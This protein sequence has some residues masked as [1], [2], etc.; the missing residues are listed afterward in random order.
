MGLGHIDDESLVGGFAGRAVDMV[1][2]L[3]AEAFDPA[4]GQGAWAWMLV[5]ESEEDWGKPSWYAR[6]AQA[7]HACQKK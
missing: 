7:L 3:A 4:T 6:V 2:G 5:P 1:D